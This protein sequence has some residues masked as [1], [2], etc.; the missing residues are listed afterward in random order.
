[1][2]TYR[3]ASIRPLLSLPGSLGC[4]LAAFILLA[5]SPALAQQKN[6][7]AGPSQATATWATQPF[8]SEA[9][10][11]LATVFSIWSRKPRAGGRELETSK[12]LDVSAARAE[13][14]GAGRDAEYRK[15]LAAELAH[16]SD[17]TR[18]KL[19][20]AAWLHEFGFYKARDLILA[21]LPQ[22]V[23]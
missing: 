21:E 17:P 11:S 20:E 8:R 14:A 13:L 22:A 6:C 2:S 1:M 16:E 23:P 4:V 10:D 5:A 3:S 18:R 15:A 9:C 19:I 12:A 7:R